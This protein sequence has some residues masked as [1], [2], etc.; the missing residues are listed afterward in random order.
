MACC[1]GA[2]AADTDRNGASSLDGVSLADV[3]Q[4]Y[5]K[6]LQSTRDLKTSVCTASGKPHPL[7]QEVI[8]RVPEPVRAKFYGC[9]APLPL[10]IEGL[11]VLDLGSG[12]GRDCYVC[13]ALV[14][15]RGS[16]T[17]ID[18]TEEQLATAREHVDEWTR[19]LGY[20]EP[21]MRFIRGEIEYLDRAGIADAS[22]DLVISNCV[23]NLSPDKP[24]V[25]REAY[26]VLADGGELYFSDVYCDR[27]LP[28]AVRKDKVL[29][30]DCIAGAMYA[31]D[32]RREAQRVGFTDPRVLSSAPIDVSDPAIKAVVGEAKFFSITYRL[33]KLPHGML[34][35]RCEDYGQFVIYKGTVKGH[36]SAYELDDHHYIV[37][38]KPFLVCGNTAA[39]L[40]YKGV[41]WLA[42]HFEVHGTQDVHYGLFPCGDAPN[43]TPAQ[44]GAN[45]SGGACC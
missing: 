23:I 4:Y 11:R 44:Q 22:V 9:G 17:G 41:S 8:R 10:G 32:F 30:G 12:S 35:D 2:V 20:R 43:T 26:R 5:G 7:V 1:A 38:G 40:G 45:C 27:R 24:R 16:V 6:V 25:L 42:P 18:M 31:E 34:E 3:R 13:A 14:G 15:E 36:E 39:M 28:D 37:K 29:W 21:N 33:F 19:A